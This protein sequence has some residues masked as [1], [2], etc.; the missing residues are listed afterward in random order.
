MF[1]V[2]KTTACPALS[3]E[4]AKTLTEGHNLPFKNNYYMCLVG[5]IG[6]QYQLPTSN[7]KRL[8]QGAPG[9]L[10]RLG[11]RLQLKSRSQGL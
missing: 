9:W 4:R 2:L 6:C 11:V 1:P 8:N 7:I 10:S 5:S 3:P